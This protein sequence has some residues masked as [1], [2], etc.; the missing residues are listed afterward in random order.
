MH[1]EYNRTTLFIHNNT[2]TDGRTDGRCDAMRSPLSWRRT[3]RRHIMGAPA[4]APLAALRRK[5]V[6]GGAKRAVKAEAMRRASNA[7]EGTAKSAVQQ[8]G[9]ELVERLAEMARETN[10][11]VLSMRWMDFVHSKEFEEEV[12]GVFQSASAARIADGVLDVTELQLA[13]DLLHERLNAHANGC[14]PKPKESAASLMKEFDDD[15][16]GSLDEGEFL[17]FAMRYFSRLEWPMWRVMARGAAIGLGAY[18]A[19]EIWINPL[20]Q[21]FINVMIPKMIAKIKKDIERDLGGSVSDFFERIKI[22]LSDGNV[23]V[24]GEEEKKSL[25]AL[26]RRARRRKKIGRVKAFGVA[27]VIGGT[28]AAAGLM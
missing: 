16:S 28:S 24:D 19:H 11:K 9:K 10:A 4:G 2:W 1:T 7:A 21:R 23:F 20:F 14:L 26:E 3:S 18:V 15:K 12:L 27:A 25:Q 13:I 17:R 8:A 22:K 5:I 6:F